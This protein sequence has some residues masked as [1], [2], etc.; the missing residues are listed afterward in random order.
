MGAGASA[1]KADIQAG[2][3]DTYAKCT[4]R[5]DHGATSS[6]PVEMSI[7]VRNMAGD[8]RATLKVLPDEQ[9]RE[10]VKAA[11]SLT[12]FDLL[13][14]EQKLCDQSTA[15][16]LGLCNGAQLTLVEVDVWGKFFSLVEDPTAQKTEKMKTTR[17][18]EEDEDHEDSDEDN[19]DDEDDEDESDCVTIPAHLYPKG[20]REPWHCAWLY[21]DDGYMGYYLQATKGELTEDKDEDGEGMG[22]LES[23]NYTAHKAC[24]GMSKD[25]AAAKYIEVVTRMLNDEKLVCKACAAQDLAECACGEFWNGHWMPAYGEGGDEEEVEEEEEDEEGPLDEE[26]HS[27]ENIEASNFFD[28]AKEEAKTAQAAKENEKPAPETKEEAK[29]A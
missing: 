20:W 21:D 19:E 2:L 29:G 8:V 25:E 6:A 28:A 12:L 7:E 15:A 9:L 22:M 26:R 14:G 17:D 5:G 10:M 11:C 1:H 4:P 16:S 3:V 13:H 24:R 27:E 18:D 23:Y